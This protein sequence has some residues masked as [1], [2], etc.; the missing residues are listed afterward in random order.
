MADRY[1]NAEVAA[2][3][4]HDYDCAWRVQVDGNV[5]SLHRS[6]QDQ[7]RRINSGLKG[8]T[9]LKDGGFNH[10]RVAQAVPP[11]LTAAALQP[12]EMARFE[13]LFERVASAL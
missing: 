10:Y 5:R 1:A 12:D 7:I 6:V 13:R 11:A 9:L 4:A 2:Q 8:I 3:L